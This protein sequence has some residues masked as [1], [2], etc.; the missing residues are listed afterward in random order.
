M[1]PKSKPT[2]ITLLLLLTIP[3]VVWAQFDFDVDSFFFEDF[4]IDSF[5]VLNGLDLVW[6]AETYTPHTYQGRTLPSPGSKVTIE[7][8]V[9]TS[10][11]DPRSLKY[12]WFLENVFQ[13]NKSGYARDSFYFYVSQAPGNHHTVK[14]QIFNESRSFFEERTITIP[15]VKPELVIYPSNG[16]SYFFDRTGEI[17]T[18]LAGKKF[19]FIAKPYFFSIKKLTD[20]TF[21]WHFAE[22]EPVIS[23]GY[24]ANV[25]S[26]TISGKKD[27][28][29]LENNLW[30]KARNGDDHRQEAFQIIK[31]WVY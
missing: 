1:F 4:G 3:L 5:I 21:E 31:V 12:S 28:E 29:I 19:S 13:R 7:A 25:L 27:K 20:L 9:H 23:S 11:G 10:G 17:S 24:D 22:Q 8:I 15:I 14:L 16:N 26:L 30:V 18:I 6:T 2:L